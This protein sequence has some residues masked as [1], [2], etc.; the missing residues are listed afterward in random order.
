MPARLATEKCLKAGLPLRR[1]GRNGGQTTV[2]FALIC[3]PFFIILFAIIDFAEI[4]FYEGSLQNGL[5][6][7][8]RFATA[9]RIIQAVD[10]SGNPMFT[11]VGGVSIPIAIKDSQGR[12]SS[13]NECIRYWFQSNC[14]LS[15]PP[16]NILITSAPALPGEDATTMTNGVGWLFLLQTNGSPAFK[17]PGQKNDYVQISVTFPVGTITP[18]MEWG[19]TN[20]SN[21]LGNSYPVHVSA[22]VK[23]EPATLN[24][25]HLA[26]YS[27][28]P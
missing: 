10:A 3:L 8:C 13:R 6:E 22:I 20:G 7:A 1:K 4:F 15:I 23:N 19:Y 21:G 9:G 18:L 12:E 26:M 14:V 11:N 5:R 2:E 27:N 16:S 24:F 17:G 28:E 25:E